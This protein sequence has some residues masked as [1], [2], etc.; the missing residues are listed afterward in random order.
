MNSLCV[1]VEIVLII[2]KACMVEP[3]GSMAWTC[4]LLWIPLMVMGCVLAVYC[5]FSLLG[6]FFTIFTED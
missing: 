5:L 1:V 3:F 4:P 2:L 6:V